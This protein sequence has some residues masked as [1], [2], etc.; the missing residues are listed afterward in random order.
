MSPASFTP[1]PVPHCLQRKSVV[2]PKAIAPPAAIQR[3]AITGNVA[4]VNTA[5]PRTIQ[6]MSFSRFWKWGILSN[7]GSYNETEQD[8]LQVERQVRDLIASLRPRTKFRPAARVL[9]QEFRRIAS[10]T[11][12]ENQY[13][14]TRRRLIQINDAITEEN[15][16]QKHEEALENKRQV[17]REK[18]LPDVPDIPDVYPSAIDPEIWKKL[19]GDLPHQNRKWRDGKGLRQMVDYLFKNFISQNFNYGIMKTAARGLIGSGLTAP[20]A[21][22]CI[23]YARAFADVLFSVGIDAETRMVREEGEGRFIVRVPHFMDPKVTGHIYEKG[24]LKRG[25]YMFS[26][27]AATWVKELRTYYDPMSRSSYTSLK[28]F[29]ECELVS[30]KAEK[31]FYPRTPAQTLNPGYKW[32]LVLTDE[33]VDG[34]FNRL[35]L[36]P[37]D[38]D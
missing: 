28:P 8:L 38:S 31:N 35:E 3:K 22:N 16:I 34:D 27:H 36:V 21:G 10:S 11:I 24:V 7:W 33:V 5:P 17:F 25:Y 13:K 19:T 6:L 14:A 30:D 18:G 37:W 20:A 26:S 29:I 23:A 4:P 12:G 15:D 32:K 9:I 2:T 1:N